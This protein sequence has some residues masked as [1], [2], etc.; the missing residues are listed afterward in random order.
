ML[1]TSVFLQLA[2]ISIPQDDIGA[3]APYWGLAPDGKFLVKYTYN[4]LIDI[5]SLFA[6]NRWDLAW[7]WPNT[8]RI[9]HFL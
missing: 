3:N 5:S 8:Q 7:K 2:T 4:M 1:P 9:R 6:N